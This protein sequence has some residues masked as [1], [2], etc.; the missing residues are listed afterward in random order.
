[1]KT[2]R[3]VNKIGLSLSLIVFVFGCINAWAIVPY[4]LSPEI[5]NA[6][7]VRAEKQ[8]V[9]KLIKDLKKQDINFIKELRTELDQMEEKDSNSFLK[10]ETYSERH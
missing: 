3:N 5:Q 8:Q 9:I 2:I 7:K 1:M 4:P 6:E 10:N